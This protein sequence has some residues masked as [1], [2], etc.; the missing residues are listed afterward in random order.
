MILAHVHTSVFCPVVPLFPCICWS[1]V[2]HTLYHVF[3]CSVILPVL[4]MLILCGLVSRQIV[5]KV[6]TCYLSLCSI[7]LSHNILFVTTSLVL[8]LF[9]FQSCF[10]I[11]VI[12]YICLLSQAF[13]PGTSLEPAVIPTAQASSFTLPSSLGSIGFVCSI[14]FHFLVRFRC[15]MDFE[16]VC[17]EFPRSGYHSLQCCQRT[18]ALSF[19][20]VVY[21]NFVF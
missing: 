21:Y 17:V 12:Q 13:L 15:E 11:T 10:I 14:S 18:S 2:V 8:P 3:L 20:L 1:A 6:C 5:G 16:M 7:F 4:G 19:F 9:H